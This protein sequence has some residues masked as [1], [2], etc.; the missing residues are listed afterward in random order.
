MDFFCNPFT[1]YTGTP[2]KNIP[3]LD[4]IDNEGIVS[5]CQNLNY[6]SSSLR[7]L[8]ISTILEIAISTATTNNIEHT[9]TKEAEK[10]GGGYNRKARGY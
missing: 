8:E 2:A 10:K 6:S 7:N 9:T 4:E 5:T 1:T 3:S